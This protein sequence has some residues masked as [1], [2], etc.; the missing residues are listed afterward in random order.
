MTFM[1]DQLKMANEITADLKQKILYGKD[2]PDVQFMKNKIV[3]AHVYIHHALD[4]LEF[5]HSMKQRFKGEFLFMSIM[6][7][8][9]I[10]LLLQ[11]ALC[12]RS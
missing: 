10:S 2:E 1:L 7:L 12:M 9:W 4:E 8:M 11:I 3:E 6:T 5:K